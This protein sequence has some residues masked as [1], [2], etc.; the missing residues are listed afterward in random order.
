MMISLL[1]HHILFLQPWISRVCT[2][3]HFF[4][5]FLIELL[6]AAGAMHAL[7]I[8]LKLINNSSS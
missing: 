3:F 1:L 8:I 6:H 7:F 5:D 2:G 4:I